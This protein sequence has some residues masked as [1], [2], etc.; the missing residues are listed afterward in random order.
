M[1]Q[2][3]AMARAQAMYGR[4]AS[5]RDDRKESSPEQREAGRKEFARLKAM[6]VPTTPEEAKQY[7]KERQQA[8]WQSFYYRYS[9]GNIWHV[10]GMFSAFTVLGEGDTWA[11]AVAKAEARQAADKPK[12][13]QRTT[14]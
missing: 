2:A 11:E 6:A 4:T 5:V 3:Q 10:G 1:N 9:V 13:K 12:K 14:A 7:R 8:S